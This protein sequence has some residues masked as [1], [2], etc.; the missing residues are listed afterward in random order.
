MGEVYFHLAGRIPPVFPH[1]N[2]CVINLIDA[3]NYTSSELHGGTT[4]RKHQEK[5]RELT[6]SCES[7][8][9]RESSLFPVSLREREREMPGP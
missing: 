1:C 8:G 4:R 5:K 7:E 6:V 9:E 2:G 3:I